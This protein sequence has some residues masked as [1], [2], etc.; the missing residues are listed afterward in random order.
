MKHRPIKNKYVL[1]LKLKKELLKKGFKE[2]AETILNCLYNI[3]ESISCEYNSDNI[4]HIRVDGI[5]DCVDYHY[6][7]IFKGVWA[8][9]YDN[10]DRDYLNI[11]SRYKQKIGKY[12][13][14]V[15]TSDGDELTLRDNGCYVVYKRE[16]NRPEL[17]WFFRRQI[18]DGYYKGW[19]IEE[20]FDDPK[21]KRSNKFANK[22][23][24]H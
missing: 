14:H 7:R 11:L 1:V 12:T 17:T 9:Y 24:R 19:P 16:R 20:Y 4:T 21:N 6:E 13:F 2:N 3:T 22:Y 5:N 10:E 8:D 15:R 23:L 18:I